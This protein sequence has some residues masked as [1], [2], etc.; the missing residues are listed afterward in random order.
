M[1]EPTPVEIELS[2]GD[3]GT[4]LLD[5]SAADVIEMEVQIDQIDME[6]VFESVAMD[7]DADV[8][9]MALQVEGIQGAQGLIGPG[10]EGQGSIVL[11]EELTGAINGVNATFTTEDEFVPGV[12]VVRVNGLTQ[13][14]I[15]DFQTI[16]TQTIIMVVSPLPGDYLSA[17]YERA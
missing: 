5:V 12:V 7:V 4:I 2:A 15:H 17:D 6:V 11:G 13:R 9:E 1:S 10:G 14:I 3:E 16:G 8:I